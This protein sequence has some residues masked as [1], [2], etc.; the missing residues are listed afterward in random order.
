MCI[1][2]F[3]FNF[4]SVYSFFFFDPVVIFF[5]LCIILFFFFVKYQNCIFIT[6]RNVTVLLKSKCYNIIWLF[7]IV[8]HWYT[9]CNSKYFINTYQ[10]DFHGLLGIFEC[11][12][13][14]IIVS[15]ICILISLICV[16]IVELIQFDCWCKNE[17]NSFLSFVWKYEIWLFSI[18]I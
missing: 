15:R 5:W 16:Y 4:I 7:I 12:F 11:V 14:V 8:F 9:H 1:I 3:G 18:F 17:T 2:T 6:C 13:C 10:V